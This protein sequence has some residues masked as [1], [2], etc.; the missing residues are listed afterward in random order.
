M[1]HL[2]IYYHSVFSK[3]LTYN[4]MWKISDQESI[5][6]YWKK[7]LKYDLSLSDSN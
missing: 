1:S 2:K 7:K 6:V 3:S 5:L 4:V